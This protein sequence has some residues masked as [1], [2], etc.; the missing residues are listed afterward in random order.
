MTLRPRAVS[1][2]RPCLL[3]LLCLPC[4]LFFPPLSAQPPR[5]DPD[6]PIVPEEG[7]EFPLEPASSHA[8]FADC[9]A[10]GVQDRDGAAARREAGR[11]AQELSEAAGVTAAR[12]EP[13]DL[14]DPVP[15]RKIPRVNFVDDEIFGTME[16]AGVLPAPI[17]TDAEFLRRVTLDL[18]GRIPDAADVVAF[19]ADTAP[20]KRVKAVDRLLASDAFNDRWVLFLDDL[21]KDTAFAASGRLFPNGRN[22]Y[23]MYFDAAIRGRKPLDQLVRELIV[24]S[25]DNT[26]QPAGNFEV[27]GIQANGPA[28]D[29]YDNLAATTGAVFLGT[30]IFCTSCHNG[31]GHTNE[32]NLFLTTVK[33]SDFWGMSAFWARTT[34]KRQGTS[35][36][37][38]F[39]VGDVASGDYRLGTTDGN[40]TPRDPAT[41]YPGH[42]VVKPAFLLTGEMPRSGESYRAALARMVT[43]HPQFARATV[44]YLWKEMFSVGIVEPADGF[45]LLRQDPSNPPPAPWTIQ[46]THP[47]L[48]NRLAS[49]LVGKGYDLRAILRVM[50]LSSAYQLSSFY[51]WEWSD[52]YAPYFARHFPRRLRAEEVYDAVAKATNLQV[53]LPVNGYPQPVMWAGQLPDVVNEPIG[54]AGAVRVFLDTFLRGDRDTE[55]RSAQGSISQALASLNNRVVTDRVKSTAAGSTL[56]GLIA[57]NAQVPDIVKTLYLSTLS[58]YPTAAEESRAEALFTKLT[59]GQTKTSVAEDLQFALL[60]KLDFLFNY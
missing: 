38:T 25:G 26:L 17:S 54:S 21:L 42:T 27:R 9:A 52:A 8:P 44:N 57:A 34:I 46:P 24:G 31:A 6:A 20:D 35:P 7:G 40:K 33:R 14:P 41:F 13:G 3:C 47:D 59:A 53:A 11:L 18:T 50:A 48:L 36:N 15:A 39:A 58:R 10:T 30:N 45:D 1:L 56:K 2:A 60:N 19:V 5:L 29:T 32:I 28:Q 22:A 55:T 37:Y 49:E 43:A 16:T 23:H 4:L 51:P 12:P